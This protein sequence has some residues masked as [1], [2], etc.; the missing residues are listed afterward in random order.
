MAYRYEI[1]F[2]TPQPVLTPELHAHIGKYFN[3][4]TLFTGE[5]A[6]EGTIEHSY[7]VSV[8]SHS[9]DA[10]VTDLAESL[11]DR[12]EQQCVLVTSWYVE[13]KMI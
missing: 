1:C 4:Y 9:D 7:T 2:S 11:R 5:G 12:Y 10:R 8:V 13:A 3:G 6:W